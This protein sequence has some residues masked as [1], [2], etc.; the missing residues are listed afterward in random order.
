MSELTTKNL[1]DRAFNLECEVLSAQELLKELKGE[2][3]YNEED[4][5]KGLNKEEVVSVMK[6]AKSYA[7]QVDLTEKIEELKS[8]DSLIEELS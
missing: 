3:T 8:I 6:A 1:F 5:P 7:K 2:F 4:N